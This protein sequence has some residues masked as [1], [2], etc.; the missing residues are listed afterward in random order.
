MGYNQGM[1]KTGLDVLLQDKLGLVKGSRVGL[2][3]HPAAVTA[4]LGEGLAALMGAGVEVRALYGPEH[5]LQGAAADGAAV[6]HARDARSGLPVFS[7]Y[8][9]TREP[10]AE[11][12]AGV[13][14]LVFD[15]QDVGVRFYTYLSTLYYVLRGAGRHGKRVV[16]LDRPNPLTGLRVEGPCL[17]AGFESF[18]GILPVTLR[19]G[20]TLGELAGWINMHLEQPAELE[21]VAMQGWQRGMWFD[22]TGRTWVP[23]SPAM[24]HLST[25]V[26]YPGTCLVEGTNLSEGRG[27][28][29]PFEL[30]GAPWADGWRL[31]ARLNE[32]GLAGVIFRPAAFE[33]SSSKYAGRRCQGV[34][35][36]VTER[37]RFAALRCGLEVVKACRELFPEQ[38]EFLATSW[39]GTPP[40]F[41]LLMGNA[42][43]RTGLLAGAAVPDLESRWVE[44]AGVFANEREMVLLYA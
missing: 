7:L 19:H 14:A 12:L 39:E 28:A 43:V 6:A 5:G 38:F 10:D 3:T 35:V 8:G 32:V 33:P 15:M 25:A 17:E 34:Q 41:D 22:E 40:H 44:G 42:W 37:E 16:V 2:V 13:D 9:E 30:I 23:T 27:T 11:M 1:I 21:V 20:L 31:A 36:H 29:L 24:A 4:G 18:V 26:V